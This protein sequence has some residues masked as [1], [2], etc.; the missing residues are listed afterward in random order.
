MGE[1][2]KPPQEIQ[3]GCR[4]TGRED[5]DPPSGAVADVSTGECECESEEGARGGIGGRGVTA[6]VH[7]V[8]HVQADDR[9]EHHRD[10]DPG[11]AECRVHREVPRV[12]AYVVRRKRPEDEKEH[13]ETHDRR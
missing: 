12:I 5:H 11:R 7:I 6:L 13:A 2:E 4:E 9:H 1:L 8:A 3:S 10:G